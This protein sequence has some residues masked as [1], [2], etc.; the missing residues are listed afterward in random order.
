MTNPIKTLLLAVVLLFGL[1]SSQIGYAQDF[2]K[3][4]EAWERSDYAAALK[5]WRPLAEQG[6]ADAQSN[7]G[8]MYH[9]GEGVIQDYKEA[10]RL[11]RLAAEQG[12]AVAQY[13]LGILYLRGEGVI[14]DYKESV[15]WWRLA[16]EQGHASAQARLGASYLLG[17]GV[18]KDN[19]YAHMWYNIAASNG[20]ENAKEGRDIAANRMTPSQLEK[21][22]DLARECV[23]K[24]YKDC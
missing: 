17:L 3:G 10:I 6:D 15:K 9:H 8:F 20:W 24:E 18:I 12:V 11:Y 4:V 16:A 19:V 21:A 23:K 14:Q 13:N 22:T 2:N 5:E 7:L 1:G